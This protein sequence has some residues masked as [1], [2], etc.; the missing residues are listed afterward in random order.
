MKLA[1]IYLLLAAIATLINIATQDLVA[2]AFPGP[3]SLWLAMLAGTGA[4]LVVKYILDK[5]YIFRF[6]AASL[7]HDSQTFLL[8]TTAGVLTTM[9]F[10]GVEVGFDHLFQTRSAR[11]AG[12]VL[13]LGLGYLCKYRLDKRFVF[14]QA[15]A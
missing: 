12:A 15:A 11:Y 5:R 2:R 3:G 4:G 1:T 10:W 14:R 7:A 9:I 6:Q 8:Y 13:G